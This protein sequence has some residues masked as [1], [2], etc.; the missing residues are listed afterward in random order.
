MKQ[1]LN[2]SETLTGWITGNFSALCDKLPAW[3]QWAS[4]CRLPWPPW[5]GCCRGWAAAIGSGLRCREHA[6]LW[7]KPCHL[8]QRTQTL[9]MLHPLPAETPPVEKR[10]S[11]IVSPHDGGTSFNS[12]IV[13][14]KLIKLM[15]SQ[16]WIKVLCAVV[17]SSASWIHKS[18]PLC[19][20]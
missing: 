10:C 1:L 15:T 14:L 4:G 11:F 18:M 19:L 16:F 8:W 7:W 3:E 13:F 9:L 5:C 20:S 12:F 2:I 17:C 6:S